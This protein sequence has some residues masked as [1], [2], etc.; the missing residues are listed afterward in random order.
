MGLYCSTI[1]WFGHLSGICTGQP[2]KCLENVRCPSCSTV[3][4]RSAFNKLRRFLLLL[5]THSR[6][7][8]YLYWRCGIVHQQMPSLTRHLPHRSVSRWASSWPEIDQR[9][10]KEQHE[11][12]HYK[13]TRIKGKMYIHVQRDKHAQTNR[14][15]DRQTCTDKH[16]QTETDKQTDRQTSTHWQTDRQTDRQT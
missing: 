6:D 5:I 7:C 9:S 14:Q 11:K 1:F 12:D 10:I 13:T 3:Y 16:A 2:Q 8:I 15:T 4:R